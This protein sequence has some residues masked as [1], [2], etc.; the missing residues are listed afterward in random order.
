MRAADRL[1]VHGTTGGEARGGPWRELDENLGWKELPALGAR[2]LLRG[3]GAAGV[4]RGL[5]RAGGRIVRSSAEMRLS[6]FRVGEEREGG[7]E[8]L[9]VRGRGWRRGET[10]GCVVDARSRPP[11]LKVMPHGFER[12]PLRRLSLALMTRR[13]QL[14]QASLRSAFGGAWT[15]ASARHHWKWW[16]PDRAVDSAGSA[17]G[18]RPRLGLRLR[19]HLFS[20]LKSAGTQRVVDSGDANRARLKA[21]VPADFSPLSDMCRPST[22]TPSVQKTEVCWHP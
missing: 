21:W 8:S 3:S 2:H 18:L 20:R 14:A 4:L 22:P 19:R 13:R 15:R 12:S 7:V 11:S 16:H 9:V 6:K 1:T 17:L 5:Y 10:A